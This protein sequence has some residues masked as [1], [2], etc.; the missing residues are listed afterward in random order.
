MVGRT[1]VPVALSFYL[2]SMMLA[3]NMLCI[4]F[5]ILRYTPA[6]FYLAFS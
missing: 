5:I 6:L 3:V 4:V 2:F 1:L